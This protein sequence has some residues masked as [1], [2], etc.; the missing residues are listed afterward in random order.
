MTGPVGG[1]EGPSPLHSLTP[2][3]ETPPASP[4]HPLCA[5]RVGTLGGGVGGVSGTA[6]SCGQ[7]P[8]APFLLCESEEPLPR[9]SVD[10]GPQLRWHHL[11]TELELAGPWGTG[12]ARRPLP[13]QGDS[14]GRSQLV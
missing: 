11:P 13:G 14:I 12:G 5:S 9:P 10:P 1:K 3:R 7:R 2:I 6:A 8:W 4:Q